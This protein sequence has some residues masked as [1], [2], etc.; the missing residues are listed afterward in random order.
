M[1]N[2]RLYQQVIDD[3]Q[4]TRSVKK[5]AQRTMYQVP[6]IAFWCGEKDKRDGMYTRDLM[7]WG[8][9]KGYNTTTSTQRNL[10]LDYIIS[11]FRDSC[12]LT[13]HFV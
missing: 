12:K 4:I 3:Y 10:F 8:R 1:D 9:E 2:Q 7:R 13:I 6:R 5:T 11:M